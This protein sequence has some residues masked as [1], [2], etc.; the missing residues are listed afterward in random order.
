MLDSVHAQPGTKQGR[1]FPVHETRTPG[2]L[3]GGSGSAVQKSNAEHG[4]VGGVDTG[5]GQPVIPRQLPRH[6]RR[7]TQ[8]HNQRNYVRGVARTMTKVLMH[9]NDA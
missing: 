1:P 4:A 7:R 3:D 2:E 6:S 9:V 5:E 8:G